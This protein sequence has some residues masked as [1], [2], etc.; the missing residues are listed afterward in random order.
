MYYYLPK[1]RFF[2][3]N[4]SSAYF[5]ETREFMFVVRPS[6]WSRAKQAEA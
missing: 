6:A 4:G 1:F 2:A 3:K 5:V